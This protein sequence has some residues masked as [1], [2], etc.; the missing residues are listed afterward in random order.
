MKAVFSLALTFSLTCISPFSLAGRVMGND[1]HGWC[2]SSEPRDS[3]VCF[4]Y[5][6]G[7]SDIASSFITTDIFRHCVPI[8]L[9][10]SILISKS[11]AKS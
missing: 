7:V 1:L 5:I 3:S 4:G 8:P 9:I 10:L 2:I 6:M 11:L